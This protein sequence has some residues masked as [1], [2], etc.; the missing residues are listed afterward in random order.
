MESSAILIVDDSHDDLDTYRRLLA[1]APGIAHMETA[2]SGQ[3]ALDLFTKQ[4]FDCVLLDYNLPGTNGVEILRRILDEKPHCPVVMLTGGGSEEVAVAA[5]KIGAA[6]YLSKDTLSRE[7]LTRVINR[8]IEKKT[9]ERKLLTQHE[10]QEVFLRV[11]VHDVRVPLRHASII[12]QMLKDDLGPDLSNEVSAHLDKLGATIGSMKGLIDTLNN[13]ALAE[14]EVSFGLTSLDR[15]VEKSVTTS[16]NMIQERGAI[17]NVSP[18]PPVYGHAPQLQQ[19]FQNLI[20]NGIKFSEAAAPQVD[21]TVHDRND[22]HTIIEVRDNGIGIPEG[23]LADIFEPFTRLWSRD[24][25]AGSGLGLTICRK[26]IRRHKGAI[27][28]QS[29]EGKGTRF[30]VKLMSMDAPE[31]RDAPASQTG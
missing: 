23:K 10:E 16:A 15:V 17:V 30:F 12:S 28:C 9:L 7:L 14:G 11:L 13:Y 2:E 25:Y 19:V 6:D 29:V 24:R 5:M 27:W 26:V 18:L 22:A 21:I 8:A 31:D 20:A 4:E 3:E 1:A